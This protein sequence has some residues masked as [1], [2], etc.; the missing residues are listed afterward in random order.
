MR[1][2]V[3]PLTVGDVH[4]I[5]TW[6]YPPPYHIYDITRDDAAMFL[7]PARQY[8]ALQDAAGQLS[9]FCCFGKE[10]Q[11]PGWDY[12]DAAL[13]IGVGMRPELTGR[14]HGGAFLSTVMAYGLAHFGHTRLR[15]TVAAFN[16][17]SRRMCRRQGFREIGRFQRPGAKPLT[18][19]HPAG[20]RA[21]R[22]T[23]G[24]AR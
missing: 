11:V 14:G 21:G 12:D 3:R 8:H 1:F 20:A 19:A 22:S 13:D 17:R 18:Q 24:A 15:V 6:R 4:A 10:G 23:P 16:Q 7:D 5:L 2:T 9:G